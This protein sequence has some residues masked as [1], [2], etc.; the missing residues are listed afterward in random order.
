MSPEHL[1]LVIIFLVMV[2][3]AAFLLARRTRQ[4]GEAIQRGLGVRAERV[5]A[6]DVGAPV[7][8]EAMRANPDIRTLPEV[9]YSERHGLIG[10]PDYS[11]VD[12][13]FYLPVEK[14]QRSSSWLR[15]SD[16]AQVWA[17]CLLLEEN[18]Y[19]TRG[20]EVQYADRRFEVA[21]GPAER[22]RVEAILEDMRRWQQVPAWRVPKRQG[23]QCRH[24]RWRRNCLAE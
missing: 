2:A 13:R 19:P 4:Q 11:V 15:D 22:A 20:G 23:P 12:G 8:R 6:A 16:R 3:A 5:V 14:K 24:C 21:Y 7:L 10:K 18:G 1:A 9:L 17:Y